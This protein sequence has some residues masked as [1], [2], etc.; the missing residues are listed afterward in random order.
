MENMCS[1]GDVIVRKLPIRS[2]ISVIPGCVH[3]YWS[4]AALFT[5]YGYIPKLYMWI[6][7]YGG[8]LSEK[9]FKETVFENEQNDI[10]FAHFRKK[11]T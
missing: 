2:S 4:H 8:I 3:I 9:G 1:F 11:R 6:Y 5:T 10:K 7:N